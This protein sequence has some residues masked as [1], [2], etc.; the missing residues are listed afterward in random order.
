M[1]QRVGIH[2]VDERHVIDAGRQVR[3]DVRDILATLTMLAKGP[4]RA[5]DASLVLLAAAAER[6]D[7]DR[8]AVQ[9]IELGLVVERVDMAG[10]AVHEQ[11][12]HTLCP[13]R[14]CWFPGRH[15]I[16][17]PRDSIG[18]DGLTRQEPIAAQKRGE[19]DRGKPSAGFPEQ[20]TAGPAAELAAR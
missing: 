20:L 15:R 6:V 19:G 8:L 18:G 17:E 16:D 14:E 1:D 7:V 2:R 11:E 4:F 12:D 10:P 5:D 3:E 9:P 13:G